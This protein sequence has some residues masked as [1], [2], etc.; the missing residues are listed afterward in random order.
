[1]GAQRP[2]RL[3]RVLIGADTYPPDVNGASYF[4]R[5]LAEGLVGRGAEVHVVCPSD[6]GPPGSSQS[7]GVHVHRMRS[8][9]LPMHPSMRAVLPLG[10]RGTLDLIIERVAP[11]AL[12]VQG[13][14]PLERAMVYEGRRA[15][16]PVVLT[17]HFM[18]DNLYSYTSVPKRLQGT[19]GRL[20][21]RD[22]MGVAE[23]ADHVTTPTMRAAQLLKEQGFA[24][25]VEAVSCGI[26][27][28]RFHPRE[29][30]RAWARRRLRLPDRPTIVF[31]GRLDPEKRI[32]EI[33]R[34]LPFLAEHHDAQLALVGTGQ[35]RASLAA[36]AQS[37]GVTDRVRFLGFVPDEELPFAYSAADAFAIASV[38]ELQS[39]ATLEA[40]A[41]GLPIVAAE[42]MALGHLVHPGHNGF[43]YPPGDVESLTLSLSEILGDP[44]RQA[45]MGAASRRMAGQH[46]LSASLDRFVEIYT[47]TRPTPGGAAMLRAGDSGGDGQSHGSGGDPAQPGAALYSMFSALTG[48]LRGTHSR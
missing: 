15:G 46:D 43:L 32:D 11:H 36:L 2:G 19:V 14:F 3:V 7:A 31:V 16:L 38:A 17:N 47:G 34:A 33:I 4:T 40:M 21:W 30:Q 1:M 44:E 41:T 12:H 29:G 26:D 5:R 23:L 22:M 9:R 18:P 45:S 13:H 48:R 37:L 27:L 28:S 8:V 42:A 6:T 25:E 10:L 39:I 35:C 20:A 24:G